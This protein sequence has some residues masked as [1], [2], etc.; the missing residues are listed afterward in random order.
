MTSNRRLPQT[1]KIEYISQLYKC[2]KSKGPQIEDDFKIKR[3]TSSNQSRL[4]LQLLV[5]SSPNLTLW[6][7]FQ[8]NMTSDGK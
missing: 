1:L 8:M 2:L 5:R 7:I 3:K 6:L 4:Y